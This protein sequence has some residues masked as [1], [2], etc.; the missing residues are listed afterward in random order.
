[1]RHRNV[2]CTVIEIPEEAR[3]D[4][5]VPREIVPWSDPYISRLLAKHRLEAALSDSL[6]YLHN[7][8]SVVLPEGRGS[9]SIPPWEN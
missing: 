6:N 3:G 8:H 1:M 2:R 4:R 5:Y 9:S 7:D